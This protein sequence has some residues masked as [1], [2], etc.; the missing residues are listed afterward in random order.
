MPNKIVCFQQ[1]NLW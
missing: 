1:Q